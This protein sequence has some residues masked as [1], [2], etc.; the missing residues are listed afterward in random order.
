[1]Y[2][3]VQHCLNKYFTFNSGPH[4]VLLTASLQLTSLCQ[5]TSTDQQVQEWELMVKRTDNSLTTH[6][7]AFPPP[8]FFA[9]A[10]G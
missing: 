1:M 2:L 8:G 4:D 9:W 10:Q 3:S 5:F 6:K 7:T